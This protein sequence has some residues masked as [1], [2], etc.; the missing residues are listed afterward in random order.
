MIRANEYSIRDSRI[1][2][3]MTL[4]HIGRFEMPSITEADLERAYQEGRRIGLATAA[5]ALSVVAFLN[6]LG[7]EKSLLAAVLAVV[8]LRGAGSATPRIIRLSRAALGVAALHVVTIV[9]VIVFY[10][11]QLLRLLQLLHKLS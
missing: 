4:R 10:H 5:L 9:V 8:A 7:L 3:E 11:D 6:L 2:R 1:H